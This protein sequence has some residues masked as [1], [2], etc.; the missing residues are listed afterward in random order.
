MPEVQ[1]P[2]WR[3]VLGALAASMLMAFGLCGCVTEE[4]PPPALHTSAYV[5]SGDEDAPSQ[6]SAS[7]L[8]VAATPAAQPSPAQVSPPIAGM[9]PPPPSQ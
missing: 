1:L 9:P 7:M 6:P 2:M 4:V 3:A 5:T 8:G